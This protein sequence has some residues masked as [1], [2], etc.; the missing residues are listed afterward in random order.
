LRVNIPEEVTYVRDGQGRIIPMPKTLPGTGGF[1]GE[2][3]ALVVMPNIRLGQP[4]AGTARPPPVGRRSSA[5][6]GRPRAAKSQQ[7][8]SSP[9]GPWDAYKR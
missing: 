7:G 6:S 2:T 9:P 8:Q 4:M 1:G 5:A 3:N